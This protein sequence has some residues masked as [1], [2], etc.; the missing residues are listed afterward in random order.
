MCRILGLVYTQHS[1]GSS[2][3]ELN[4]SISEVI[5][6]FIKAS[7]CDP[8]LPYNCRDFCKNSVSSIENNCSHSDGWGL[9][10]ITFN[11]NTQ[12]SVYYYR[13]TTPIYRKTSS[14]LLID[15]ANKILSLGEPV[16]LY[17][18]LH[19]RKKSPGEPFGLEYTHPFMYNFEH[20][21]AW[22]SHN[23][24][25]SKRELAGSLGIGGEENYVDSQ[26]LGFYI[27]KYIRECVK[28]EGDLEHCVI[29]AYRKAKNYI[30]SNTGFNTTLLLLWKNT[31][32]LYI[33]QWVNNPSSEDRKKYYDIIARVSN[34]LVYTASIT[35]REYLPLNQQRELRVIE[36][37]VYELKPS[38]LVKLGDL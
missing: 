5:D 27:V 18:V 33:S 35:I 31:V 9:S 4:T 20:G 11:S 26:L 23:G 32:H 13:S 16:T 30:P 21:V 34:N 15:V 3:S 6:A 38:S 2:S 14:V 28:G 29:E 24:S 10:I 25:A 7:Q 12:G 22:F 36:P 8:Y 1:S 19:S 37:G 17:L